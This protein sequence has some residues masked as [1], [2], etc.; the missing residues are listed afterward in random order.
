M[1]KNLPAR[2][3]TCIHSLGWED[4]LEKEM[5]T[6]SSILAWRIPWTD[7]SGGLESM[8]SQ[9]VRHNWETKTTCVC[10]R[11]C[12][13]VSIYLNSEPFSY[14]TRQRLKKHGCS[15]P[16]STLEKNSQVMRA[17][18]DGQVGESQD[19]SFS[20]LINSPLLNPRN[21]ELGMLNKLDCI[22]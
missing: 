6:H 7:E 15:W 14:K 21:L 10:V 20:Y 17:G 22:N 19:F 11:V 1:V 4:P 12:V 13:C 18:W 2:L 9:R 3:E 5:A 16:C 8:V